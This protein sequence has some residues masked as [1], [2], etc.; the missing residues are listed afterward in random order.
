MLLGMPSFSLP[1]ITNT[2]GGCCSMSIGDKYSGSVSE[3]NATGI[4]ARVCILCF[5]LSRQQFGDWLFHKGHYSIS[6]YIKAGEG[7]NY[8]LF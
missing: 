5:F 4:L 7:S 2:H 1:F 6:E 8:F 3:K